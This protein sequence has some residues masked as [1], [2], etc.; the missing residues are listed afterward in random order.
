[1]AADSSFLVGILGNVI[2]ILVF[3]SP[4]STFWRVMKKKSTEKYTWLPYVTTLLTTSMWTYYG[5]LKTDGLLLVTVNGAGTV[6]QAIYVMLFLLFS[7]KD[8]RLS[9]MKVVAL[10][11]VG[12]YGAV[13]FVTYF[14]LR[15][16]T[17]LLV[18]GSMGA[19]LTV[20]M[21]AAPLAAMKLVVQLKSVEYMPFSLSFFLFL[22][23]GVW[24]AYSSLVKDFFIGVPNGIGFLLG[25]A[26]LVLYA[27][28]RGK[29]QAKE[30]DDVGKRATAD[31][32][33]V[34][35]DVE[36]AVKPNNNLKKGKSLPK[37]SMPRE[38]RLTKI[39]KSLSL[40]PYENSNWNTGD[41]QS[42]QRPTSQM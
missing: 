6:L 29:K 39:V 25:T 4:I 14:A 12:L 5:L 28:Y 22:N 8:T 9:M 15:G 21:Y 11:N 36:M 1:M 24:S 33:V 20:G 26:Q 19:A 17:R 40:P 31:G 10:L 7:N 3:A 42:K 23:A 35:G 2:S 38:Q 27:M 18:I 34:V 16:Q 41:S 32:V 37:P 30:E 13:V